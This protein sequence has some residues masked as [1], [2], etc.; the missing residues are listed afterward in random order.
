MKQN[1][2]ISHQ[3][4]HN[5]DGGFWK[6]YIGSMGIPF[7]VQIPLYC[8]FMNAEVALLGKNFNTDQNTRH[9]RQQQLHFNIQHIGNKVV[10]L[11]SRTNKV[12]QQ[13]LNLHLF[14][15]V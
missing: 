12:G 5:F 7:N 3:L 2:I 15:Q 11:K 13:H 1:S 9:R 14:Q 6:T 8:I 10:L 4:P